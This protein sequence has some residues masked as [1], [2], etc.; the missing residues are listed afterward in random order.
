MCLFVCLFEL[1]CFRDFVLSITALH[2]YLFLFVVL[3]ELLVVV[4]FFSRTVRH[5]LTQLNISWFTFVKELCQGLSSHHA[6]LSDRLV[7][8]IYLV[9]WTMSNR[10]CCKLENKPCLLFL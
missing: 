5:V 2:V 10:S 4:V 1:A 6:C 8:I 9:N 3:I 7:H